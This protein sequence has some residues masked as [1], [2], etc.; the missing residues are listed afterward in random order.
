MT[1]SNRGP[2]INLTWIDLDRSGCIG[3]RQTLLNLKGGSLLCPIRLFVCLSHYVLKPIKQSIFK[4]HYRDP[5]DLITN[6]Q[7]IR[8]FLLGTKYRTRGGG[9]HTTRNLLSH[10]EIDANRWHLW[11]LQSVTQ[12]HGLYLVE[13]IGGQWPWILKARDERTID[14]STLI[15][16]RFYGK[17]SDDSFRR[18]H[19]T[20]AFK[21]Q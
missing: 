9:G 15:S 6:L 18:R 4:I 10:S 12:S 11:S 13:G 2:I 19:I 16:V 8:D 5:Q 17:G 21:V 1:M 3:W 7:L 14:K 20:Q